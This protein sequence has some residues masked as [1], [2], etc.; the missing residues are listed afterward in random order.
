M[1]ATKMVKTATDTFLSPTSVT[2]IDVTRTT[3]IIRVK[4]PL[5]IHLSISLWTFMLNWLF[6]NTAGTTNSFIYFSFTFWSFGLFEAFYFSLIEWSSKTMKFKVS[7][8][9]ALVEPWFLI[10]VK[11]QRMYMRLLYKPRGMNISNNHWCWFS[12]WC[13]HSIIS[14]LNSELEIGIS[15]GYMLSAQPTQFKTP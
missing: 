4:F 13:L 9:C 15:Q 5:F 11:I 2:N 10:K 1:F 6:S 3:Y 7:M 14:R 8:I 12:K